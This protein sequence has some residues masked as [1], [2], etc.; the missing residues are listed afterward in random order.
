MKRIFYII[1]A[2]FILYSPASAEKPSLEG[3]PMEDAVIG[4]AGTAGKAVVSISAEHTTRVKDYSVYDNFF[5][6]SPF[7]ED[8]FFRRF[9]YD[10]IGE[11]P[12][13]ELRQ[14]G[15]G[16]GAVINSDGYIL[17]NEHVVASASKIV[18]TL[19]DGRSFRAEIKGTDAR[20]DLAVIKI[21]TRGLAF[22]L[23]GDSDTLKVGQW[24]VAIGNPYAFAMENPEP[25][26]SVGVISALH[27]A[28]GSALSQ[29]RDYGNLIQTDA[30]INPGNSGGPL[31]NLKG[32]VVGINTAIFSTTGGY[33]G[34][35]FA[36]P[37]NN[38][39]RIIAQLSA[40]KR[41][42][43][44][45]LGVVVQGLN[46]QLVQYFGLPDARGVLVVQVI[47]GGP[48]DTG[49]LKAGD[50]I[51]QLDNNP[52]NNAREFLD[53]IAQ[54]E[55]SRRIKVAVLRNKQLLSIELTLGVR[56]EETE[57]GGG[58]APQGAPE[59]QW[60]GM[61]VVETK[62]GISV[63]KVTPGSPAGLAGIASGDIIL[64]INKQPILSQ[65]DYLN[66]VS[67]LKGD[68]LVRT[69]RGYFI[70]KD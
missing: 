53:A 20:L 17:T 3:L 45:W 18:V 65:K 55:P 38:A 56:P 33:Q 42:T 22:A 41:I 27:R 60:R 62:E 50:L 26:V 67:G 13:R 70:L 16:S 10:F 44:G 51:R 46:E 57:L 7:G 19:A 30:A 21:N 52:V 4:V 32:E 36:I 9:F 54:S 35:G 5:N 8:E 48:A 39:K 61:A 6:R 15:L 69:N 68:C 23:L 47:P 49:G 43:R 40:G 37:I 29:G 58:K 28:L 59:G 24:V 31:V 11:V 66:A 14:I 12:E 34:I 25:T 64:E 1:V 63:A 2:I